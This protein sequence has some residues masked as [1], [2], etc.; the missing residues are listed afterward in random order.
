MTEPLSIIF[1]FEGIHL[2]EKIS[3]LLGLVKLADAKIDKLIRADLY[4]RPQVM[5]LLPRS[6]W[7]WRRC[8]LALRSGCSRRRNMPRR[9][10]HKFRKGG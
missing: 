7:R 5:T 10:P 6:Y 2:T 4:Q 8:G 9:C 1:I 3:S